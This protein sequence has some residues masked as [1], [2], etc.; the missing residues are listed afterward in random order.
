MQSDPQVVMWKTPS[1]AASAATWPCARTARSSGEV[2]RRSV[3]NSAVGWLQGG[4]VN[5][6]VPCQRA[7][8]RMRGRSIGAPEQA[9]HVARQRRVAR[10]VG[11]VE[12]RAAA[13]ARQRRQRRQVQAG[14]PARGR[15][16]EHIHHEVARLQAR[17][18]QEI[19]DQP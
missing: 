18:V 5:A 1:K 14:A 8:C 9:M 6:R 17:N 16:R 2:R 19:V 10:A 3:A 15:Q 4:G 7:R 11:V 13:G 12:Q